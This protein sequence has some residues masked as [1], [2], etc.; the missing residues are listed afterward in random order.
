MTPVPL[1]RRGRSVQF[2]FPES[3]RGSG[4]RRVARGR[5]KR[6]P[7]Q[8]AKGLKSPQWGQ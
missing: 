5:P 3:L 2:E 7:I 6:V 4:S 8:G 1:S